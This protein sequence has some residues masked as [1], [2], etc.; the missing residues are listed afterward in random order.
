MNSFSIL[1][2]LKD[3]TS[4]TKRLMRKWNSE[5]F[6]FKILIA[7]GGKS[8]EIQNLLSNK[9]NFENLNYEY[10][11]H[12]FDATLEDFYA[13]MS[14][15][16]MKI[17]TATTCLMDNDDFIEVEGI[18]RCLDILEDKSYSSARGLMEDMNG[19]NIYNLYPDSIIEK[20]ALE[21]MISQTKKFHGNWHNIAKTKHIQAMWKMIQV[22]CPLNFRI[23][24][25]I[26]G[27]LNT[28]WGNSYRGNF[29]WMYHEYGQRIQTESGDLGSHFPSQESWINSNYWLEEFN[30]LTEI[31]GAAISY[32]D[33]IPIDEALK[34][35]RESYHFKIPDLKGLLDNRISQAFD[36]GYNYNKIDEM[37]DIMS[38]LNIERVNQ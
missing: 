30:K 27:Y 20:T 37:F 25:Q 19:N 24:E 12:P 21:R 3:R 5:K 10:I 28:M 32:H 1:L 2:V 7:D 13:K 33:R 6:P 17:D 16:V 26:T 4:Y 35:F 11:K 36:L 18:K 31:V 29:P 15:A 8:Q 23:V 38:D 14:S 9:N 34:I 22:I